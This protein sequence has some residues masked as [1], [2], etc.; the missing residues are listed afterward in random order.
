MLNVRLIIAVL[1]VVTAFFIS[2]GGGMIV[3]NF[4]SQLLQT[5]TLI[6]SSDEPK[7]LQAAEALAMQ[8]NDQKQI[9]SL[10]LNSTQ[11]EQIGNV[12][13][14]L[15]AAA[16]QEDNQTIVAVCMQLSRYLQY[17]AEQ[18]KFSLYNLF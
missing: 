9:L 16:E 14:Q 12:I 17:I 10:F 8:W 5:T 18:E 2:I 11:C 7:Q 6:A 13:V 1:L 4:T 15:Q 3:K